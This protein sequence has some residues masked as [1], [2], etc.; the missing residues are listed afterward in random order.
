MPDTYIRFDGVDGESEN[1]DPDTA[2]PAVRIPI[3][4]KHH[5]TP[6]EEPDDLTAGDSAPEGEASDAYFVV[7]HAETTTQSEASAIDPYGSF[8]FT[9]ELDGGGTGEQMNGVTAFVDASEVY[10]S[11]DGTAS[12]DDGDDGDDHDIIFDPDGDLMPPNTPVGAADGPHQGQRDIGG[13]VPTSIVTGATD[14]QAPGTG[15][16]TGS[17]EEAPARDDEGDTLVHEIGHWLGVAPATG[18]DTREGSPAPT[19]I[20][21]SV[22]PTL[23]EAPDPQSAS[24]HTRPT[25]LSTVAVVDDS[26]DA[27]E[28][29]PGGSL[30]SGADSAAAFAG[31][32]SFIYTVVDHGYP[33]DGHELTH[34]AQSGCG[35][36]EVGDLP[37]IPIFTID[38]ED[39]EDAGSVGF[40]P[41]PDEAASP[42]IPDI[43]IRTEKSAPP[44]PSATETTS[45]S[46][47]HFTQMVWADT[48]DSADAGSRGGN[49]GGG[50][51]ILVDIVGSSADESTDS[52]DF[53]DLP[54]DS[55]APV[56]PGE[57]IIMPDADCPP[58][59]TD[60]G[61]QNDPMPNMPVDDG[62]S[63]WGMELA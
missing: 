27:P 48:R 56:P 57:I 46:S 51:F 9:V 18:E 60:H 31:S 12:G 19:G 17:A 10:G 13:Y 23:E 36:Q 38:D 55:E 49:V 53:A 45:G 40:A 1:S 50:D 5:I 25:H 61:G 11:D 2:A 16:D 58:D 21:Q 32:D 63:D 6:P 39:D 28:F 30:A 47:G 26:D 15:G 41:A 59:M 37:D 22:E 54:G 4:I 8:N 7:N 44:P 35:G 29:D 33:A 42:V 20:M 52:F 43:I 34:I 14:L 62:A 24:V 3:T